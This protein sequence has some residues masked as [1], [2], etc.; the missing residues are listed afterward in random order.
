M[1]ICHNLLQLL[2][3]YYTT[4]N[5]NDP[6]EEAFWKHCGKRIKCWLPAFS[7]FPTM[8]FTRSITEIISLAMFIMSSANPL[9]LIKFEKFLFGKGLRHVDIYMTLGSSVVKV[10]QTLYFLIPQQEQKA[11]KKIVVQGENTGNQYSLS[12]PIFSTTSTTNSTVCT[13]INL[14]ANN[15]NLNRFKTLLLGRRS[16][17][18]HVYNQMFEILVPCKLHTFSKKKKYQYYVVP[19]HFN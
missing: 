5:W 8:F 1:N 11:F 9:N 13:Q 18:H 19:K 10:S 14:S 6:L 4:P 3:L 17:K 7:P 16:N 15:F 2:T 12:T